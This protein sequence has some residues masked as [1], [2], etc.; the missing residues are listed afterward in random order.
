MYDP[1]SNKWSYAPS[2][3]TKRCRLGVAVLNRKLYCAGGYDGSVF[4]NT[5]ECYDTHTKQWT[6]T[7]AMNVRRSRVALVSCCGKLLAIGGYDGINNLTSLECYN[8]ETDKWTFL[9]PMFAHEG[10]VG[11]GII[12]LESEI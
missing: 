11:V 10:G 9:S 1:E 7:K 2:M 8:P 4:L 5:V 3:L 12:P 6:E